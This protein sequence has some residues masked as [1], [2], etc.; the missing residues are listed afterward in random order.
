M[1]KIADH[2]GLFGAKALN[3]W[4]FFHSVV[5]II[6]NQS[7]SDSVS[8]FCIID[9]YNRYELYPDRHNSSKHLVRY[10]VLS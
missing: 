5:K 3:D 4:H 9:R 8:S 2:V 7:I 6:K 10:Q 1:E